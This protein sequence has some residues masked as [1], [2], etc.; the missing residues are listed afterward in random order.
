MSL[1]CAYVPGFGVNLP[2]ARPSARNTAD[3]CISCQN[4]LAACQV[5]GTVIS[6]VAGLPQG[7]G[8]Y[9]PNRYPSPDGRRVAALRAS[10]FFCAV[11]GAWAD[12]RQV[13]HGGK[14]GVASFDEGRF[15]TFDKTAFR[16]V[17]QRGGPPCIDTSKNN[18]RLYWP[19]LRYHLSRPAA[20]RSSS[21][22]RSGASAGL[23]RRRSLMAI[24]LRAPLSAL[25]AMSP[26]VRPSPNAATDAPA[27]RAICDTTFIGPSVPPGAGGLC[28][29]KTHS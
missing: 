2:I 25:R 27:P 3:A 1:P 5:G 9:C 24:W 16:A 7:S 13:A 12:A 23:A 18:Q 22:R 26:I 11:S 21:R 14:T 10:L 4:D 19:S 17:Q 15:L 29:F 28:R 20:T 8:A 6:V